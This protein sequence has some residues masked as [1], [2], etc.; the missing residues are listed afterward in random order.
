V[1]ASYPHELSG[2][3]AQRVL[4]A[5]AVSCKPDLVIADEP[6]TALDVTVQAEILALLRRLNASTG[7]SVLLITHDMGVVADV[8]DRVIVLQAGQVV[9]QASTERLFAAPQHAYTRRLLDSMPRLS[10][11]SEGPGD[12]D[13]MDSDDQGLLRFERATVT[14][15]PRHGHASITA[16]TDVSLTVR[17]GE[18][19]GLVGGSG[20]GKTTLGRVAAGLVPPASG[21]VLIDGCDLARA[22]ARRLRELRHDLAFVHQDPAASLDPLRTVAESI[23]EPLDVHRVGDRAARAARVTEL[24]GAV[25]LPADYAHRLPRELSGGQRQRV[26]LAR[27]LALHPRLVIADEPTSALDVSVQADVLALLADLQRELG[28]ACIFI[29][30]DLAVVQQVAD[31]VAV[32]RAGELV[33]CGPAGQVFGRPVHPYTRQ[34]LAAVPASAPRGDRGLTSAAA[35][36]L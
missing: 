28:F 5:G 9:E 34:L 20:S 30:H 1:Y 33:E 11:V 2:G 32:M 23:R 6:T 25:R 18:I 29:S 35:T 13:D 19:L 10:A 4:I 36:T 31:R 22:S 7:T 17:A 27:A 15:P 8:A 14:Y 16:V 3:M 26:V 21:R 24:L 12:V